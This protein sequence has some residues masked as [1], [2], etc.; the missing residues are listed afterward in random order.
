M[1][2][3]VKKGDWLQVTVGAFR[4]Q[5]VQYVSPGKMGRDRV[6]LQNAV[7][8]MTGTPY[9]RYRQIPDKKRF[10]AGDIVFIPW[11]FMTPI[12]TDTVEPEY[13]I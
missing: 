10:E 4:G 12:A 7:T 1:A 9:Q 3:R 6:R 11:N 2:D 13:Y 8:I 5:R